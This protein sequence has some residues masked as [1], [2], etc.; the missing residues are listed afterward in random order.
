MALV[1]APPRRPRGPYLYPTLTKEAAMLTAVWAIPAS[2]VFGSGYS[3]PVLSPNSDGVFIEKVTGLEPV[4]AE[5]TTNA[6]NELD[7]E[8]YV[9]SRQGKRNI[10]LSMVME[11]GRDTTVSA[12]RRML[13]GYL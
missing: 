1:G 8:F 3:F 13:Y 12:I 6:Y 4:Q 9:S 11:A 7:G 2:G 10:V 5:I